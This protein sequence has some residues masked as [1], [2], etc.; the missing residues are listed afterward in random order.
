MT[1][2]RLRIASGVIVVADTGILAWGALALFSPDQLIPGYE[3]YTSQGWSALMHTSPATGDFILVM[4]RLVGALNI[5]AALPLIVLALTA[6]LARQ[7]WAWWTLLTANTIAFGAPITY[8]FTTGAIGF[9]EKLEWVALASVWL[10]LAAAWPFFTRKPVDGGPR[11]SQ[12][13]PPFRRVTHP[14]ARREYKQ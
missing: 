7:R 12:P 1:P 9:F 5:A 10:A 2:R 6:F 13:M 8:D 3:H 14:Q 11:E 4:F